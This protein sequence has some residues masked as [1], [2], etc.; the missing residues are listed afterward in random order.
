MNDY[1]G[2]QRIPPLSAQETISFFVTGR[3]PPRFAGAFEADRDMILRQHGVNIDTEIDGGFYY[4]N[5]DK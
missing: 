2:I 4:G 1:K 5:E 3:M